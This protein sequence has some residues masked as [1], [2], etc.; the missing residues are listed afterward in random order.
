MSDG[1]QEA[2]Q[3][4]KTGILNSIILLSLP[5]LRFQQ[6]ILP[7]VRSGLEK[8][9]DKIIEAVEHFITFELHALLML[10]DPS[11]KLRSRFDDS[12]LRIK[13]QPIL[14]NVAAGVISL[15]KAQEEITSE[16]INFLKG[17]QEPDKANKKK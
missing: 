17:L 12:E 15:V 8:D 1:K 7:N 6:A 4:G 9:K 11:R 16:T 13:L 2:P 3:V 10:L 5:V 14:D